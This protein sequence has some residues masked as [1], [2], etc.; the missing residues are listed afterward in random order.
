VANYTE[1]GKHDVCALADHYGLMLDG[2]R[3]IE[4][5]AGNSSYLLQSQ[6]GEYVL[7][8]FDD[9]SRADVD[10]LG[11]LLL[12]LEEHDFPAT[13]LVQ[14]E[15]GG[16]TP[17]YHDKPVMLKEYIAGDV[18]QDLDLPMLSQVGTSMATLHQLEIPDHLLEREHPY[19]LHL[20]G[21]VLG[22]NIDP[23][24]ESWLAG[25]ISY[26]T[27]RI[28]PDV[29]RGLIHGDLFYDNLLFDGD[30]LRAII[31]FEEA[32]HYFKAFDLGMGI[33][34]L[35][36]DD[37]RVVPEKAAALVAGYQKVRL[38][39]EEERRTLP[40]FAEYAATATSYWRYWKYN[41]RTPIEKNANK[42]WEMAQLAGGFRDMDPA[43]FY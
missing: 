23:R 34:G 32:C 35:C 21:T 24:Y 42:H 36:R 26:L 8:V 13:R 43:L 27:K 20:F 33:V 1:L 7:T 5:G 40:L 37:T 25:Q 4:G 11:R 28:P 9:R 19:G 31:D 2:F 16:M 29:P 15:Q 3:P 14:P 10:I 22:Q 6:Q 12:L 41:I 39:K 30:E 18:R 38:L 17:M